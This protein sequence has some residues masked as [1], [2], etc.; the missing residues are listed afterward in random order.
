MYAK[1]N[2]IFSINYN[3]HTFL[4]LIS[5]NWGCT[6]KVQEKKVLKSG[7]IGPLTGKYAKM[8]IGGLNSFKLAVKHWNDK[9]D[10]KYKYEV[11]YFD[12]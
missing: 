1:I 5:F 9:P 12:D 10:T 7:F 11:V 6:K 8:G 3:Y 4:T 2:K